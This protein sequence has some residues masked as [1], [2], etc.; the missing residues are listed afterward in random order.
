MTIIV[1]GV[2]MTLAEIMP[3][4]RGIG[5]KIVPTPNQHSML[6]SRSQKR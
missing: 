2:N 5:E 3:A 6:L 4:F 1:I